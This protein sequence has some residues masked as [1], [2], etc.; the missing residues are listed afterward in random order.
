LSTQAA[1]VGVQVV[2][3]VLL[4]WACHVVQRRAERRLVVQGG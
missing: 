1:M 3:A 4:L 2:W